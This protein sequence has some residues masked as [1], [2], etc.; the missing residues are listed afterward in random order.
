[1]K[2]EWTDQFLKPFNSFPLGC[3]SNDGSIC[4]FRDEFIYELWQLFSSIG[5][6][7]YFLCLFVGVFCLFLRFVVDENVVWKC[8]TN[9]IILMLQKLLPVV[10]I[11]IEKT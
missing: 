8:N 3:V 11:Y 4:G 7:E 10:A 9:G 2:Y 5:I 1:M 6:D